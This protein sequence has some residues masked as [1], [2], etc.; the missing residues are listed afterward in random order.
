MM[1]ANGDYKDVRSTKRQRT[2]KSPHHA[3]SSKQMIPSATEPAPQDPYIVQRQLDKGVTTVLALAGFDSVTGAALHSLEALA[4]EYI[5]GLLE[6][7]CASMLTAR[8]TAPTPQDIS[9]AL[10][11]A[12]IS[13]SQLED[14]LTLPIPS[15]IACPIIPCP[16]PDEPAPIDLKPVLGGELCE[17]PQKTYPQIPVHFPALPSKHAWRHTPYVAAREKDPRKIRERATQEGI[18]AEKS[19]RKLAAAAS[20]PRS[21]AQRTANKREKEKMALWQDALASL[22][23]D[24]P[25]DAKHE[26][27]IDMMTDGT[28]ESKKM[29]SSA[30]DQDDRAAM[31]VNYDRAHWRK[32]AS[33]GSVRT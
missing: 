2:G 21:M 12:G 7:T 24:Q 19:L 23:A 26:G 22:V 18:L 30:F 32:G 29:V 20:K 16:A 6:S 9:F 31:V 3:L 33:F 13:S 17:P 28:N 14:Q 27:D 10:S 4:E 15:D 11:Q 8:R 25:Q 5:T 1:A